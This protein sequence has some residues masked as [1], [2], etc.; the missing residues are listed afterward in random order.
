MVPLDAI[1]ESLCL[2]LDRAHPPKVDFLRQMVYQRHT[3]KF[4][5]HEAGMR[6]PDRAAETGTGAG[7]GNRTHTPLR[8]RDFKSPAS[9]VPP[10]RRLRMRSDPEPRPEPPLI[11][12]CG[13]DGGIRTP[14]QGFA[15]PCLNHLATSPH[16]VPRRG[17]EPLR[18]FE[19]RPLKTACLPIPP[20]RQHQPSYRFPRTRGK[21]QGPDSDSR[22]DV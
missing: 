11:S 1:T 2:Q 16:L 18:P 15:D 9:T 8:T 19:H 4:M 21:A 12:A 5:K 10:P 22:R 17:F 3:L 13:G 7:G 20:P 14:D 6:M